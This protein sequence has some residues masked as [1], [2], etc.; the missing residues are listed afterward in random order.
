M[1]MI[2]AIIDDIVLFGG[3]GGDLIWGFTLGI[4]IEIRPIDSHIHLP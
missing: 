3:G 1:K 4:K 2:Q